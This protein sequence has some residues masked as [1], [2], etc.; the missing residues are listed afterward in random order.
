MKL[1]TE[2]FGKLDGQQ[3]TK[4]TLTNKHDVS[5]SILNYGGIWQS[6]TVPSAHGS[7]NLLYATDNAKTYDETASLCASRIIGRTAGRLAKGTFTIDGK[8][9]HVDTNENGN[10]LHGGPNGIGGAIWHVEPLVGE[11]RSQLVL[12]YTASHDLDSYPGDL[13]MTVI[14]TL[15][16]ND[17][18]TID[19]SASS[20]APTLFNPTCHTY[21]N[22]SDN[23][24]TIE[25]HLL[26]INGKYHLECDDE[27]IPT[28]RL[29]P[30]ESTSFDFTRLSRLGDHL[31]AMEKNTEG[32]FDDIWAVKPSQGRMDSPIVTL[33]DG[34]SHRRVDIFSDRN[35]LVMYT[36]NGLHIQGYNRPANQWMAIALEP[37]TLPDTPNHP[38]FGDVVVRTN[39]PRHYQIRYEY[40]A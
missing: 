27:K 3:I 28:G 4:Y 15:D 30:V 18:V 22:L 10:T 39:Q 38:E 11:T 24:N 40:H 35:G 8:E 33:E 20:T 32:G 26:Q 19:F 23:D 31:S 17:A 21:W 36:A 5:I 12:T 7:L 25:N 1:S 6:F 29:L 16:D 9:Y 37:Q 2:N 34:S 13:K 14:Y